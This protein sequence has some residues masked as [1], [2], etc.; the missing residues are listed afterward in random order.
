MKK[1]KKSTA[2]RQSYRQELG[3]ARR[4]AS[5]GHTKYTTRRGSIAGH[6]RSTSSG[7][8]AEEIKLKYR[9]VSMRI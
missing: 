8:Q 6:A 1:M 9:K 2:T 5:H 3:G 4:R 7:S